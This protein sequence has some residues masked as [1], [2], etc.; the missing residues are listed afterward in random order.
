MPR[1][2]AGNRYG[3][4]GGVWKPAMT[5]AEQAAAFAAAID[6]G[7][8]VRARCACTRWW[9]APSMVGELCPACEWPMVADEAWREA[10]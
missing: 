8:V 6:A 7:Q 10:A 3:Q 5:P 2:P 9:L 4:R 1:S